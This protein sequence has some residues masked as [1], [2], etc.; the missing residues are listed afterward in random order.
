MRYPLGIIVHDDKLCV[1][2]RGNRHIS[3]FQLDGQFSHIIASGHLKNP[4]Y[5]AVSS[6]DQLF[7]A[8]YDY[9]CI[10]IFTLD[11]NYVGKFGTQGTSGQL[12]RPVGIATDMYGF[13]LVT[14]CGN[15][16]VSIFD[17]DGVFVHCLG[18]KGSGHGPYGIAISS[19]GDIYINDHNNKRIQIFS[20]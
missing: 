17:K 12:S 5:I 2:D 10:S 3:V 16:H 9:D 14:E 8:N 19:T 18:S 15:H 7:V 20:T 6:N 4:W 11:G 1:A 13:I